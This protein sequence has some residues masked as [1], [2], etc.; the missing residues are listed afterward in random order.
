MWQGLMLI[1]AISFS[2]ARLMQR[3][4]LK[5]SRHDPVTYSI[6]FQFLVALII[7]PIALFNNF[8]IPPLSAIWPQL[9]LMSVLYGTAS[10]FFYLALKQTQISEV[11][12]I[13]ATG[14]IWTTI[15]SIIFLGDRTS[16]LKIIGVM[17]AVIGVAF[18]FYQK[19]KFTFH[20][21]HFCAFLSI[22]FFGMGLTNDSFLLR[23]FNQTT[24]SFLYY[25][26]PGV[27]IVLIN[28]KKILHIKI[29]II[30]NSSLGFFIPAV[31][32]AVGSLLVN[33]SFQMGVQ[34]SQVSVMLQLSPIFTIALG[35][36]FLNERENLMR[37]LIGGIIVVIGVLMI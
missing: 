35:A 7:L 14:P 26:L 3:A 16:F 17:L 36:I 9:I 33:T 18:V 27:F 25:F 11:M 8:T 28:P 13:A 19:R 32:S 12:I 21:G 20:K 34:V 15:T 23:H 6:C 1:A 37:K 10:V 5:D 29:F 4:L 24:Y 22:L 31:L 30:K 2:V